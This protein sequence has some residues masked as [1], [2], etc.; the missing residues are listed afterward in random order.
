MSTAKRHAQQFSHQPT[1]QNTGNSSRKQET[2]PQN[3]REQIITRETKTSKNC[4][5]NSEAKGTKITRKTKLPKISKNC[6][7]GGDNKY[8]IG[9]HK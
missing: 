3:W 1:I 2:T 4:Q 5:K 8:S 9:G 6:Q 7:V